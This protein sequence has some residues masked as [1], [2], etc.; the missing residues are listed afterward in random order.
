VQKLDGAFLLLRDGK[1]LLVSRA[2]G[3]LPFSNFGQEYRKVIFLRIQGFLQSA[4]ILAACTVLI[5]FSILYT[6]TTNF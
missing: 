6:F 3:R 1:T 2:S 5:T 4:Y